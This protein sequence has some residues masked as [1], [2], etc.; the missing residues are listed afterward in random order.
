MT[1]EEKK[2]VDHYATCITMF[3]FVVVLVISVSCLVVCLYDPTMGRFCFNLIVASVV[4]CFTV[5]FLC[6][7]FCEIIS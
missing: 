3:A 7:S 1:Y 5:W 4:I 6:L 2:R